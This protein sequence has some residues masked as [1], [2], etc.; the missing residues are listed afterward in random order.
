MTTE[1]GQ[2]R[3][4]GL[5]LKD[6]VQGLEAIDLKLFGLEDMAEEP[7]VLEFTP[8]ERAVMQA[9]LRES[10]AEVEI[11][12]G[13]RDQLMDTQFRN[14]NQGRGPAVVEILGQERAEEVRK[15]VEDLS[16]DEPRFGE[17]KTE[18]SRM[19]G[20]LQVVADLASI[21]VLTD[22]DDVKTVQ[23]RLNRR[24]WKGARKD[25]K[26]APEALEQLDTLF[27]QA[28]IVEPDKKTA[29][30]LPENV[31]PIWMY[32]T[33]RANELEETDTDEE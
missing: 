9:A 21:A 33:G 2:D 31:Y 4:L 23:N 29:R 22:E 27:R 14:L 20:H 19:R 12:R 25:V 13:M 10:G 28:G 16:S 30:A 7:V 26:D 3:N 5:P 24:I 15:L 11:T 8:E 1:S 17:Q 18:E 6:R 32:M